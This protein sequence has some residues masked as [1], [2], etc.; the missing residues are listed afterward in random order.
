MP[1]RKR[2]A[3]VVKA[4]V[5]TSSKNK[6]YDSRI[7][8]FLSPAKSL[9]LSPMKTDTPIPWTTFSC[10]TEKTKKVASLMKKHAKT[11]SKLQKFL[12]ISA[13]LAETAQKYWSDYKL[14]YD[15]DA[16]TDASIKPAGFCF[17][18]AAYQGLQIKSLTPPSLQYLQET[19]L[20]IDPLYG[21]LRPMDRIQP[22]RLE[23]ATRN[24]FDDKTQ[25]ANF[26]K[27]AVRQSILATRSEDKIPILLLNLASDE[28][29]AAVDISDC[30]NV[31]LIKIV[32]R[33]EG[34]VIAV[35]AKRARGLF[36]K[37]VADNRIGTFD[38]LKSFSEEG[39]KYQAK[40]SNETTLVF[41][42]PKNWKK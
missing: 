8:M 1:P 11:S 21:C 16:S 12:G 10:S 31:S 30:E 25:L 34:R 37:Y 29:S 18:G 35:H 27:P 24:L 9:D 41:D 6:K 38:G 5:E 3:T 36:A 39:Y 15:Y 42:R 22:Y 40:A 23:M 17:S 14:D 2:K 7:L 32:F 26:W 13:S 4:G 28:Y 33:Q 19:L 20:I